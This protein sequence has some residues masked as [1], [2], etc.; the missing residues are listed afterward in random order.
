MTS[1]GSMSEHFFN[2]AAREA[3]ACRIGTWTNQWRD[4]ENGPFDGD[5]SDYLRALADAI[6]NTALDALPERSKAFL[7]LAELSDEELEAQTIVVCERC[8]VVL[9]RAGE[10]VMDRPSTMCSH[11]HG[12]AYVALTALGLPVAGR[13][14]TG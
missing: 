3:A 13:E 9:G 10:R 4:P 7:K 2:E 8:N 1:E 14:A 5:E 11:L 6:L 12:A